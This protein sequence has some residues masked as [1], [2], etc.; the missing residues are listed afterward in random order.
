VVG[1]IPAPRRTLGLVALILGA[2]PILLIM[3]EVIV[4]L[5][6]PGPDTTEGWIWLLAAI[7]VIGGPLFALAALIVGIIAVLQRRGR[8]F[9][10]IAIVLAVIGLLYGALG[11]IGGLGGFSS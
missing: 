5:T 6:T 10:A 1:S 9:G 8:L 2:V 3:V 4:S 11:L 7:G